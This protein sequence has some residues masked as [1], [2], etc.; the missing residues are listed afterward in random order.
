[1]CQHKAP[2]R[3]WEPALRHLGFDADRKYPEPATLFDDYAGRG[4]AEHDQDMTIEKTMTPRDL[5]LVTPARL[6]PEQKTTW[7]AY[8]GPRNEAFRA[9]KLTGKDLVRWKFQRYMHDYL[10]L[11]QGG[12]RGRRQ[13]ARHARNAEGVADNTDRGLRRPTRGSTWA[14]TAGSTSAGF[15]RS[16]LRTPCLIKLAG[17]DEAGDR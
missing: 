7:D 2:H 5:K 9:A 4:A 1:M 15:S 8:Y 14:N 3:E 6:T 17:R 13:G 11:H 16:R 10:G 12:R